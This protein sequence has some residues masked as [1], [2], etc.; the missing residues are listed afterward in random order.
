MI[1]QSNALTKLIATLIKS[2]PNSVKG[3]A[4][5][6]M[7]AEAFDFIK[8]Q[9]TQK[10]EEAGHKV[11]E[12]ES[13]DPVKDTLYAFSNLANV[14]QSM[15]AT[16]PQW[17]DGER[18]RA[19]FKQQGYN[20]PMNQLSLLVDSIRKFLNDVNSLGLSR[21]DK[22]I[23]N[24]TLDFVFDYYKK[25]RF[26][27]KAVEKKLEELRQKAAEPYGEAQVLAT[28]KKN[29]LLA[30][31]FALM[32]NLG[33]PQSA[34]NEILPMAQEA[35]IMLGNAS[36][37]LLD[38]QALQDQKLRTEIDRLN[39]TIDQFKLM[40]PL[41]MQKERFIGDLYKKLSSYYGGD[42]AKAVVNNPVIQAGYLGT[43]FIK[44]GLS[45]LRSGSVE[46]LRSGK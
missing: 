40:T 14:L 4:G 34:L 12:E 32:V 43:H 42:F 35:Q 31:T 20:A 25:N 7:G 8:D 27:Y 9:L 17:T 1:K 10:A 41:A 29:Y 23:I 45:G 24:N 16:D 44:D 3:V 46:A 33:K 21:Y 2:I 28:L 13:G 37:E 22:N 15:G 38:Y 5:A 26:N 30:T 18:L 39:K 6:T 11:S 19:Y 36:G